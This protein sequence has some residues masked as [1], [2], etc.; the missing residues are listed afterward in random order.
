MTI[1][2]LLA[3]IERNDKA[4]SVQA[5]CRSW[6]FQKADCPRFYDNLHVMVVRLS[7]LRTGHLYSQ[8][9]FLVPISVRG[10]IDLKAIVRPEGLCQWKIPITPSRIEPTTFR[11]VARCLYSIGIPG[12]KRGLREC[13][14]NDCVGWN[15]VQTWL[16]C[17]H[18]CDLGKYL[19]Q[20]ICAL[21]V[22]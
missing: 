11:L 8:E 14:R 21:A 16:F 1:T 4:F 20:S 2:L 3:F 7:V 18:V 5:S 19:L 17:F 6:G 22:I 9:I 10:W 12:K 15:L 13:T